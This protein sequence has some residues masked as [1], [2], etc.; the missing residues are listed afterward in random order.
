[1]AKQLEKRAFKLRG[2][3]AVVLSLIRT[4]RTEISS[5]KNEVEKDLD[6]TLAIGATFRDIAQQIQQLQAPKTPRSTQKIF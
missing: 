1:M 6:R 3:A 2:Q 5:A 4:A